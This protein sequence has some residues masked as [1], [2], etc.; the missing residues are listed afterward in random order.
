MIV[1]LKQ[2]DQSYSILLA[3]GYWV[4]NNDQEPEWT[5]S[6]GDLR[7]NGSKHLALVLHYLDGSNQ[8]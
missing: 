7:A 5:P 3:K 2:L 1:F 6:I 4:I 8:Y